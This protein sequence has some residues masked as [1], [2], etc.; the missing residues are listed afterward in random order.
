MREL[1]AKGKRSYRVTVVARL[2]IYTAY[3]HSKVDYYIFA[4]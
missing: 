3:L 1:S 2:P 4:L